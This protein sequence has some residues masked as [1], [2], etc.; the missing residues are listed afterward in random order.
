MEVTIGRG[1]VAE[2]LVRQLAKAARGTSL[3]GHDKRRGVINVGPA[4]TVRGGLGLLRRLR[5]WDDPI[6]VHVPPTDA[7]LLLMR[8]ADGCRAWPARS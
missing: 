8:R 3:L 5:S 7:F 2:F 1:A 4:R 6:L